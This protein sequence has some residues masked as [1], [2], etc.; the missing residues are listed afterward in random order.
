MKLE[1]IN[2][3]DIF[4]GIFN[5][6]IRKASTSL[7]WNG[8]NLLRPENLAQH[9]NE[10]N[11]VSAYIIDL[12]E[13]ESYEEIRELKKEV[14]YRNSIHDM[15]ES[16]YCDIPR[17]FKYKNEALR[18]EIENTVQELLRDHFSPEFINDINSCKSLHNLPG[19]IVKVSDCL[20]A[21]LKLFDEVI[22]LGNKFLFERLV[23]NLDIL[24]WIKCELHK[25]VVNGPQP[26]LNESE[27]GHVQKI[28]RIIEKALV[29][30]RSEVNK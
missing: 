19:I 5:S 7:R 22:C 26:T 29:Y 1:Q 23:E 12:F 6:L 15:D 8:L 2:D 21:T 14:F 24:E 18:I 10:M 25:V 27:I 16:V 11:A 3:K 28:V 4:N 17:S 20:Q 13:I 9:I 30:L